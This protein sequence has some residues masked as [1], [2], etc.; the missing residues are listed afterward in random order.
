MEDKRISIPAGDWENLIPGEEVPIG[1]VKLTVRPLGFKKLTETIRKLKGL[2]AEIAESGV[3]KDNFSTPDMLLSIASII[4][5][6]APEIILDSCN[7]DPQDLLRLPLTSVMKI[8]ESI[9]N[10]N[11]KS[12]K[13]LVKNC[14]AL[15]EKTTALITEVSAI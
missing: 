6:H 10:V 15:A 4:L 14:L 8:L 11:I 5:N 2:I 13:G 3:T 7:L 12:Q 1:S 9:L